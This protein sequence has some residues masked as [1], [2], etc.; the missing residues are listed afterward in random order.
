MQSEELAT[1]QRLVL[2]LHPKA[3]ATKTDRQ[4]HLRFY[5][6]DFKCSH[7]FLVGENDAVDEAGLEATR[8]VCGH[9]VIANSLL[10]GRDH[11]AAAIPFCL[12]CN[13]RLKARGYFAV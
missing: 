5:Q 10:M 7:A 12:S 9:S 1:D 8:S 2:A 6:R 11:D 4:V 13:N 3:I